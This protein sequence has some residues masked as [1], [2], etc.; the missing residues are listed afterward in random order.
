MSHL[1]IKHSASGKSIEVAN[2]LAKRRMKLAK[3]Q[4]AKKQ[5]AQMMSSTTI[6]KRWGRQVLT[7][8]GEVI[9]DREKEVHIM[10][11]ERVFGP[12]IHVDDRH[13]GQLFMLQ[14]LVQLVNRNLKSCVEV[15]AAMENHDHLEHCIMHQLLRMIHPYQ[16]RRFLGN[17]VS[18]LYYKRKDLGMDYERFAIARDFASKAQS[19]LQMAMELHHMMYTW[20]PIHYGI[21]L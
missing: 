16:Q 7:K 3:K 1:P 19:L 18:L 6:C 15:F 8:L 10:C 4:Q 14:G 5:T 11:G 9:G 17:L 13:A 2:I 21:C 12:Q 20:N